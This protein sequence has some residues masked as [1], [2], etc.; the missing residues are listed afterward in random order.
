MSSPERPSSTTDCMT[1]FHAQ[2]NSPDADIVLRSTEGT[3][4]RIPSFVL[5]TTSGFFSS[6]LSLPGATSDHTDD[7]PIPIPH[8]DR[9][10]EIV[11]L[12]L[13]G[14]EIPPLHTLS[15]DHIE[16]I[17]NL[18]ETWDTPGPQSIIR[19]GLTAPAF[20]NQPLR[21]Y[22]ISSHFGWE[23]ELKLASKYTLDMD[24]YAQEHQPALQRLS[25]QYLLALFNLH[26]ARRDKL[27]ELLDDPSVFHAGNLQVRQC[28]KCFGD[29][30]NSPWR[31]LKA[32]I[33]WEMD[34]NCKGDGIGG[35]EMEEWPESIACWNARCRRPG[36]GHLLYGK[37]DTL[38]HLRGCM[39]KLPTSVEV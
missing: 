25:S 30:D 1:G 16:E 10:V 26:R 19:S 5:R 22:A 18:T 38:N 2:F 33:F 31:E 39:K 8:S 20:L 17:L 4:Y 24:L 32:K 13:S 11:L 15:Y 12:M 7:H 35:W 14:L 36:C 37:A 6:M 9:V 23:H 27:K 29:V 3:L 21:L 34:K 28:D